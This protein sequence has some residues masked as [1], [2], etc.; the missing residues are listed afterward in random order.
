MV[1]RQITSARACEGTGPL[2]MSMYFLNIEIFFH[3][4]I[5]EKLVNIHGT[6]RNISSGKRF[7]SVA[8][9]SGSSLLNYLTNKMLH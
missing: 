6:L 4:Q 1:F 2:I 9:N 5:V 3:R 7:T 8:A